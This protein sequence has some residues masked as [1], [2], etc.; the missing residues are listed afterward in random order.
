[1][2]NFGMEDATAAKLGTIIKVILAVLF[3]LMAAYVVV[4]RRKTKIK[5]ANRAAKLKAK[6]EQESAR[7][8]EWERYYESSRRRYDDYGEDE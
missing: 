5:R 4:M 7:R 8:A 3:V 1:M 6:Q 2:S